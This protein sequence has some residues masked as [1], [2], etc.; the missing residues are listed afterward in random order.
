MH[1]G[2]WNFYTGG[3]AGLIIDDAA[4]Q[5]PPFLNEP[6]KKESIAWVRVA[7]EAE[8]L[9]GKSKARIITF[10]GRVATSH[11]CATQE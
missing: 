10:C 4:N 9:R 2:W 7:V 3:A 8:Q 6:L 5:A 11:L 1:T